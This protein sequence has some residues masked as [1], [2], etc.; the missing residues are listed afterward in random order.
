MNQKIYPKSLNLDAIAQKIEDV[1]GNDG[2]EVQKIGS[3]EDMYL[4]LKRGGLAQRVT[5]LD[6]AI[7]VH[8][9]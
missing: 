2:F 1:F 3:S 8:M 9:Q 7:T 4:Q 5:G 6:Q